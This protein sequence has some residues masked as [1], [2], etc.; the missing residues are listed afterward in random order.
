MRGSQARQLPKMG[1]ALAAA[2]PPGAPLLT[3]TRALV[4]QNIVRRLGAPKVKNY[5]FCTRPNKNWSF[6]ARP[7]ERSPALGPGPLIRWNNPMRR[8][9]YSEVFTCN[10][11][12]A[13]HDASAEK[14]VQSQ[15]GRAC[16]CRNH[17]HMQLSMRQL[18]PDPEAICPWEE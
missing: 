13:T 11:H 12:H 9:I 1:L 3:R 16:T 6:C 7:K 8:T 4:M 17:Y 14:I 15:T 5:S 2:T 18:R 10:G